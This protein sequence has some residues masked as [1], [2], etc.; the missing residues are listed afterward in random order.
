M[1]RLLKRPP[2]MAHTLLHRPVT[3]ARRP[4]VLAYA[5]AGLSAWRQRRALTRLDAAARRDLGL[6]EADVYVES[7]RPAWNIPAGWL[8]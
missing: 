6:S 8:R 4:S 2:P 7:N 5:A 3:T 1:I